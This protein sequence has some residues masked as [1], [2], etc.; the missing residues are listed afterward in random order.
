MSDP[1]LSARAAVLH[2]LTA[3]GVADAGAVSVLEEAVSQRRWWLSQWAEGEPYVAGLVA[4]DVQDALLDA[5]SPWPRCT[6]CDEIRDHALVVEPELGPDP[7]W[8]CPES[9]IAVAPLGSL[10]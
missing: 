8:V 4:Q 10:R 1:L 5:G 6:A 9:G 3:R 2:D 7:R